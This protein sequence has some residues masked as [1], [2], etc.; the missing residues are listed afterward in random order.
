VRVDAEGGGGAE[1]PLDAAA[2][3]G[4]RVLDGGAVVRGGGGRSGGEHA[5]RGGDGEAAPVAEDGI[6]AKAIMLPV[7]ALLIRAG[8]PYYKRMVY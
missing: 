5:Q 1:G 8:V 4:E 2:G 3:G 7:E 6:L